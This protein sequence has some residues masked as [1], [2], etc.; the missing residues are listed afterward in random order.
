MLCPASV[1]PTSTRKL[2]IGTNSSQRDFFDTPRRRPDRAVLYVSAPFKSPLGPFVI[3]I[4]R[5]LTSARGEFA[6]VVVATLDPGYFQ[7]VFGPCSTPRT[8]ARR[9]PTATARC[10]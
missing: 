4:G 1:V 8:C 10:S 6:G 9:S 5:V 2:L 7:V 3:V